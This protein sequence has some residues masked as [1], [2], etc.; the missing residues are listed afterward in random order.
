MNT[1]MG[2]SSVLR[3]ALGLPSLSLLAFVGCVQETLTPRE[4]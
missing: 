2:S 3:R 4:V 1:T